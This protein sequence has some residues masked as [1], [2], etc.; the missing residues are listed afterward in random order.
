[1]TLNTVASEWRAYRGSLY[2]FVTFLYTSN[3]IKIKRKERVDWRKFSK[4]TKKWPRSKL[5]NKGRWN[6][7]ASGVGIR[8]MLLPTLKSERKSGSR[9]YQNTEKLASIKE[10]NIIG[11]FNLGPKK[12]EGRE[13]NTLN[14][15]S[16]SL[17]RFRFSK[18]EILR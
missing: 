11:T 9:S 3:Y 6:G 4:G 16:F 17:D 7:E 10:S 15:F 18:K 12:E 2:Y 14:L 5:S 1:M 13:M 8:K